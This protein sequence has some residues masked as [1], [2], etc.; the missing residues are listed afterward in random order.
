MAVL[1]GAA[2]NQLERYKYGIEKVDR[3]SKGDAKCLYD[4]TIPVRSSIWCVAA[5][6]RSLV[7]QNLNHNNIDELSKVIKFRDIF[8]DYFDRGSEPLRF[9]DHL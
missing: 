7:G 2:R 5:I 4:T 3:M 1:N 6:D 8:L 9:V